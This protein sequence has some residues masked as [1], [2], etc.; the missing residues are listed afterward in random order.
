MSMAYKVNDDSTCRSCSKVPEQDECIQCFMC[1]SVFHALCE[2]CDGADRLG[3]KTMVSTFRAV[4][5]KCNFKFYCDACLIKLDIDIIVSQED[6]ITS[7]EN[8]FAKMSSKLDKVLDYIA[9]SGKKASSQKVPDKVTS[10]WLDMEKL[11]TVKAPLKSVL[12]VKKA[13]DGEKTKENKDVV[14]NAIMSNSIATVDSYKNTC[15][16]LI[17]VCESDEGRDELSNIVK[18]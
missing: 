2:D 7:L 1:K 8:K 15:G 10:V 3:S 11:E 13:G 17:V 4:S 14:E 9:N 16:D 12:I 18:S 5:T 6:K